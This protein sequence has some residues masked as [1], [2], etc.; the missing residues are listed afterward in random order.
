MA[1][2]RAIVHRQNK[3]SVVSGHGIG[4]DATL[5]WL[6]IWFL[7]CHLDA[8]V[9][10][11]APSSE[12][13]HDILWK[14]LK[15]WLDKMPKELAG[16]FEYQTGY[17]RVKE[18]PDTWFAR[19]RTARKETPEAIAGLH[20]Q[21]VLIGVDEASGVLDEIYKSAEGSLT[22]ENVL[23]VLFGNGLRNTGY[24]Y[25]THNQDAQNWQRLQFSS[26]ES[27]IVEKQFIQRM[28][29]LYGVDSDE[30]K[31]RVKGSF[32][33]SEQMDDKGY[34]PLILGIKQVIDGLPFVGKKRLGIDPAG[35]GDNETIWVLRDNFQAKVVAREQISTD[36]SIARQTYS[37]IKEYELN[38]QDVTI[39]AFGAGM[40]VRAELFLI[41]HL[42]DINAVNENDK[43]DDQEIYLNKR[44]EMC[45]RG[46]NWL[47]TGGQIVGDSIK[48]E[49][50]GFVY[51]HNIAGKKKIMDKPNLIKRIGKSP[52]RA[53]AFFLTFYEEELLKS[54]QVS[55]SKITDPYATI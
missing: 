13:I 24:F 12:Q 27:P 21:H 45:F 15:V 16:L 38:P 8:Q 33:A 4:K 54:Q 10:T 48:R 9:G 49:I 47:I 25:N 19:A 23:V 29:N 7:F 26:E 6:I 5:S 41:D 28:L 3:I 43:P 31:I 30:Y 53:D 14:E 39:G 2:E 42:M 37:I 44:V 32:P 46:R 34:I 51:T 40:N 50:E 18:K 1:V 55:V 11:T 35:E 22:G 20:G 36:K 52:D 17:L